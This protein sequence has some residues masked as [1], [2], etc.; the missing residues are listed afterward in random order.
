MKFMRCAKVCFFFLDCAL[1][2][3]IG[4]P[5]KLLS[6]GWVYWCVFDKI[7]GHW[8]GQSFSWPRCRGFW[9]KAGGRVEFCLRVG[10]GRR[11]GSAAQVVVVSFESAPNVV[12]WEEEPARFLIR[13]DLS[14]PLH[15]EGLAFV[16]KADNV[17]A[18]PVRPRAA[19]LNVELTLF[20]WTESTI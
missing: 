14:Y 1:R 12:A 6:H 8:D 10:C 3:L 15:E 18:F 9:R 13:L 11:R 4:W 5:D 17:E 7:T 20:C 2:A 16:I 19:D